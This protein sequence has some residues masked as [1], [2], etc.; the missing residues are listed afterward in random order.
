MTREPEPREWFAERLNELL[1]LARPQRLEDVAH[2]AAQRITRQARAA[3]QVPKRLPDKRRVSAWRTGKNVPTDPAVLTAVISVLIDAA[4]RR[5]VSPGT[6]TEGLLDTGAWERWRTA[7]AQA[8]VSPEPP[9]LHVPIP[10]RRTLMAK[11]DLLLQLGVHRAVETGPER[12][13]APLG[14]ALP[15]YVP[16]DHDGTKLWDALDPEHPVNR[17]V[18]LVGMSTTGKTRSAA[19]M[20]RRRLGDW[21]LFAPADAGALLRWIEG[22][23]RPRTVLWLD[24]L[25]DFLAGGNGPS[26][27]AAL[28]RLL[29]SEHK[30]LAIGTLWP[31]DWQTHAGNNA[32]P[33]QGSSAVRELLG[34]AVRVDVPPQFSAM[35]WDRASEQGT[36]AFAVESCSTTRK[37]TQ[38]LAATP[39]LLRRY[40]DADPYSKALLTAAMDARRLGY[41]AL[42][43]SRFL[44]HASVGYLDERSRVSPPRDWYAR[45]L[46]YATAEVKGAV[47]PLTPLRT[48]PG[49]GPADGFQLADSL[50][51]HARSARSQV[52]VPV[53][54]WDALVT[55]AEDPD[56]LESLGMA[57]QD[58]G[59]YRYMHLFCRPAADHGRDVALYL[60]MRNLE[61]QG[62]S[63]EAIAL[64][65]AAAEA[66]DTKQMEH[67]AR[68]WEW[69]GRMDKAKEVWR[70][71]AEEGD[72][73]AQ[74]GLAGVLAR[75]G[76][77]TPAEK[78]WRMAA[79]SGHAQAMRHLAESLETRGLSRDAEHWWRRAIDAGDWWA[80]H[81]L[82][83]LLTESGRAGEAVE[84]WRPRAALNDTEA[85]VELARA[86]EAAGDP[87]AAAPWWQRA[88]DA[89]STKAVFGLQYL[90]FRHG[91]T[92]DAYGIVA[93]AIAAGDT[94]VIEQL[95]KRNGG[96][97]TLIRGVESGLRRAC[98]A[99][100]WAARDVLSEFLFADGRTDEAVAL[101]LPGAEAGDFAS[102]R[103]LIRLMW[104][105]KNHR[106]VERWEYRMVEAGDGSA[107][108]SRAQTLWEA[109][110]L[111]EAERWERR[112]L[113]TGYTVNPPVNLEYL[114]RKTGRAAEA[115][116]LH[117]YGIEP[118]GRT[119]DP[120]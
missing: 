65:I 95:C 85:I 58:R 105:S 97:I 25:R 52:I 22:N 115:D 35:E 2:A 112:S 13:P 38:F 55:A 111:Q 118:G 15:V 113:E 61:E 54:V 66:G 23:P 5:N 56:D 27:A 30:V 84:V 19:E 74:D 32:E 8:P 10:P 45:A 114:L 106:Q 18:V 51:E 60:V 110:R 73:A 31:E 116:R 64:R 79:E 93:R 81:R 71:A 76:D 69:E 89:G 119:A 33:H 107:M 3:G 4:R 87:Y 70:R 21:Q 57:A 88:I 14:S 104:L 40:A 72:A 98:S 17:L 62:R 11:A 1:R 39:H 28:R 82:T 120:W 100:S 41:R 9:V 7:A 44:K 75:D 99:G 37:L 86:L 90:L 42:L 24:E 117:A 36:L 48:S 67:L 47:A 59:Y 108:A 94:K 34:R 92:E 80:A 53:E 16:R 101:W 103:C 63:E 26:V 43:T 20:A 78:W 68:H 91:N 29:A 83:R 102:M 49:V 6:A 109:G 96:D 12:L 77:V 46:R 50:E